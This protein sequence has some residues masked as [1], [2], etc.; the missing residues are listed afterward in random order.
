MVWSIGYQGSSTSYLSY[1]L[2]INHPGPHP[3]IPQ[4]RRRLRPDRSA[5][6][7]AEPGANASYNALVTRLEKRY[8]GGLTFLTS[9]TWSHNIDN[10]TQFLDSGLFN[11][12]NQYDRRAERASANI[13]MTQSFTS[14]VTWELPFGKGRAFGDN[15]GGAVDAILGGWQVGGILSLRTG[16]PFE[17]TFPGDP[18][19]SQSTNRGDRIA[20]G[21]PQQPDN[22]QLVRSVRFCD[23]RARRLR[24]K[25]P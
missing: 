15:W 9:Y 19:N 13:D 8:S 1:R 5:V 4:A 17:V 3:T 7:L 20:D 2:N 12:A 16:F 24:Y 11:V 18:Q 6:T 14:S 23:Q 10:A 21:K 25:R 22:R